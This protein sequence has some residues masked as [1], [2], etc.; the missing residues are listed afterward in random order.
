M[1][2]NTVSEKNEAREMGGVHWGEWFAQGKKGIFVGRR[3]RRGTCMLPVQTGSRM[4][5]RKPKGKMVEAKKKEGPAGG[6]TLMRQPEEVIKFKQG[7][8]G[9]R[10]KQDFSL[11]KNL[12]T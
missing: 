1:K 3:T 10:K 5:T 8:T 11:G 12:L 4:R 2:T 7:Q 9:R 6:G